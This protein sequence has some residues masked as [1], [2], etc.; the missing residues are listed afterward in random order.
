MEKEGWKRLAI[1]FIILFLFETFLFIWLMGL[2]TKI[3][4]EELKIEEEK[5][6]RELEELRME[7]KC[8]SVI[9]EPLKYNAYA[10]DTERKICYCYNDNEIIHEEFIGNI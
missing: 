2:G 1:I 3:A 5:I 6:D 4:L 10:Y 9:C 7:E 8:I